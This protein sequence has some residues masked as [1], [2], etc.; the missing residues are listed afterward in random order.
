MLLQKAGG[1]TFD[2]PGLEEKGNTHDGGKHVR[3]SNVQQFFKSDPLSAMR[4]L[5]SSGET[6]MAQVLHTP[7]LG[8]F[9]VPDSSKPVSAP[10][11]PSTPGPTRGCT[12]Q[13]VPRPTKTRMFRSRRCSSS[14]S[15]N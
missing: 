12:V 5:P 15:L 3:F 2:L 4:S 1:A 10:A 8:S 11:H 14:T 13:K 9:S 6:G 7:N